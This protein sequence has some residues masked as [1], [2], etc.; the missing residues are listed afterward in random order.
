[1]QS[2]VLKTNYQEFFSGLKE[3][4][5]QAQIKAAVSVNKELILLY[6]Q[7]GKDILERQKKEEWGAIN[8]VIKQLAF[9]LKRE[10]PEMKGFSARNLQYMRSLAENYTDL[11]IVQ[12]VVA[13][14]PWG[15]NCVILDKIKNYEERLWYAQKTIQNGWS[16]NVLIHQIELKAYER[17]GKAIT[18]FEQALPQ[19]QSDLAKQILKDPY[20]FDFL[21]LSEQA[22]ERDI[23]EALVQHIT[24]FLLELGSGFAFVGRQYHLEVGEQDFYIDLLFYHLTLRSYIA[25]ELKAGEFKPEYIGKMNFY[26]SALDD[27]VKEEFDNSAIGIILCKNKNKVIAE[28][29]V[30]DTN[31]PI[32]IAEYKLMD[33][34]PANLKGKLPTIEE[35]EYEAGLVA[36]EEEN[37]E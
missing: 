30:R 25:I 29:A 28:Y 14:I 23:E 24:K 22:L 6:W 10:F 37:K 21:T 7:I 15:H 5:R 32:G 16:R 19:P 31:K 8:E 3:K 2:E 27:L 1:M 26:L 33:A 13:Q 17:Q 20:N 34:I 36:F 11:R 9:D 18:N 35:L 12:Q 4:V